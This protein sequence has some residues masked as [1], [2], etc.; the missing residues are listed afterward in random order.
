[1]IDSISHLR[2]TPRDGQDEKTVPTEAVGS[3]LEDSRGAKMGIL[4]ISD[5]GEEVKTE[6]LVDR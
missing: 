5:G 3:I 1:M 2:Q 6:I 4:G